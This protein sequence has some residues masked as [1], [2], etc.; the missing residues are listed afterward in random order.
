[1]LQIPPLIPLA[2]ILPGCRSDGPDSEA[3]RT[4]V[5][6]PTGWSRNS[7][8]LKWL[9]YAIAAAAL[10]YV[11]WRLQWSD[12]RDGIS[13]MLWWP[14][15]LAI[16]VGILPRALQAWRWAYLLRPA[17]IRIGLLF[18]AIYV[19]TLMNG[20]LPLCPSD[21]VRGVMVARRTRTATFRVFSSQAIE[22][23]ADG[24]ALALVAWLAIRGLRVPE[25]V[26]QALLALVALVGVGLVIG[27]AIRLQHQRLNDYVTSRRPAGRVGKAVRG[28][29]LEVLA[30]AKATK[31]LTLP[32]SISTGIAMVSMQVT[33]IWLML[34]AYRIALNPFQAAAIFGVIT[35]G[36]LLPTAPGKIG[37]WQFFCILALGL[38]GVPAA[39][40][41][42]F[43]LVAFAIWTVPSLILGG[44]ALVVSP[45]SW[46]ELTGGRQPVLPGLQLLEPAATAPMVIV[47]PDI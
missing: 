44:L 10:A 33:A 5:V 42:G 23:V 40:A 26:S 36:T 30:G 41:A 12:L 43:S 45:V 31:A 2:P 18:H 11:L 7:R 20:I 3:E 14:V 46:A 8:W 37:A 1:M 28:A 16:L 47:T 32:V 35:I 4:P 6:S 39:H 24:F 17:K 21:L 27:V 15:V 9:T 19:G 25:G 34:Y 38:F 22:R 29:S 13:H